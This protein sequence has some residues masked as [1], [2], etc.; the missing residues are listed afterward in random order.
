[1]SLVFLHSLKTQR[2]TIIAL[3]LAVIGFE[4]LIAATFS[5]FGGGV[6]TL[7]EALPEGFRGL[8]KAQGII[9][10]SPTAYLAAT[11]LRHPM[12]L[13]I[14]VGFAV[15]SAAG[16]MSRE[17]E[18]GTAFIL[19]SR[20]IERYRVVLAKVGAMAVVLLLLLVA[21]FFGVTLGAEV[22]GLPDLDHGL[23]VLA[24]VNA[25]FLLMAVAGYSLLVSALSNE[26]G[27]AAAISGG[28]A[29]FLFFVDFLAGTW[30]AASLIG[31]FSLFHYYDPVA[32]VSDGALP[33]LH[34]GVLAVAAAVGLV[35]ALVT[36]Q[37]RDITR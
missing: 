25:L 26:G 35:A 20:P 19:L 36:F 4:A 37:H 28:L 21:A 29:V 34:L 8:L 17:I 13:V 31:P 16:T 14:V 3:C 12:F 33:P 7:Y 18:R 15:T 6:E 27:K 22:F 1:M 23:L 24:Q 5:V 30:E 11:G 9:G 10:G 2:T 32:V